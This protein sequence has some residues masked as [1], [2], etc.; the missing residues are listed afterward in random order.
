[1]N[2]SGGG[3]GGDGLV[4]QGVEEGEGAVEVVTGLGVEGEVQEPV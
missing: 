4:G 1:M 3:G 2:V